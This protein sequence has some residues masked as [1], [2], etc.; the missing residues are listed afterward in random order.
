MGITALELYFRPPM[1]IA[2]LGGSDTPLE[3]FIWAEDPTIAGAA[4]TVIE[5]AITLEVESDGSIRPYLPA[6]IRFRD[7]AHFRPVAPFFELWLRYQSEDGQEHDEPLTRKLLAA[8]GAGTDSIAYVVT[9][10]NRKAARRTG[11]AAC[12][13]QARLEVAGSDHRRHPLLAA[14]LHGAG[15]GVQPLVPD[16]HP[17]ALGHFQVIRPTG[18]TEMG[19]DL[20]ALRVRF[21]PAR[22]TVYGPPSATEAPAPGTRR[23][24]MIVKPENRHLNAR[25]SWLVYDADYTRFDNP[26]PADTYDGADID[27]AVAWGVVDDTCDAIIEATLVVAGIRLQGS[28]RVFVGPPDFAPDR[29]PFVSLVDD[30]ADRELGTPEPVT[31]ADLELAEQE[32]ADLFAR[33][34]ET[35]SLANLDATR[36]NA[37][38][39]NAGSGLDGFTQPPRTDDQTMTAADRPYAS[40]TP[41]LL[42]RASPHDPLPYADIAQVAHA[43]LSEL[44][45]LIGFLLLN[46]ERV[47]TLIRPPYGAFRKLEENPAAT[48]KPNPQHRDPR[49][50]RDRA[51]DMRMPPY[52]RDSDA[53]ALSLTRRQYLQV[54]ALVD[55]LTGPPATAAAMEELKVPRSTEE[56]PI[57]RR[58]REFIAAQAEVTRNT[59]ASPSSQP[60]KPSPGPEGR[61]P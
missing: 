58:V 42:A 31:A 50:N 35:A 8:L 41:D 36:R 12:A 25:A 9:A 38:A 19:I 37:I 46:G 16:E 45:D 32:I 18:G 27:S 33:V 3:N 6:T 21:T 61:R 14:S 1:A 24:H 20:G 22:G 53:S 26:E 28:A 47:R 39:D 11:D 51:H 17:I 30:L 13:F 60:A 10:A 34:Y 23:V 55:H 56:S 4:H 29:R 59:A 5:L 7:G 54:Q 44:D 48:D 52:M 15:P 40:L 57:R 43:R 2:R 49:I